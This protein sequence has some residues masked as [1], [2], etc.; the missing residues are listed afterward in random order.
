MIILHDTEMTITG[1][2]IFPEDTN[3]PHIKADITAE[4]ITPLIGKAKLVFNE[5]TQRHELPTDIESLASDIE[6]QNAAESAR[7]ERDRLLSRLDRLV[8]NPLRFAEFSDEHKSALA[9][10][11]TALLNVPQQ[12]GFPAE[13]IWPVMPD[14]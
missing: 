8:S 11:R 1:Y 13:I 9:E 2:Q 7:S 14:N 3:A 4:K 6:T 12:A 5:K 10:Y